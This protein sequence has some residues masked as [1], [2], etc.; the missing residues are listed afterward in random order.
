[1]YRF[2][3]EPYKNIAS[4]HT[5]PQCK[6]RKVFTRYI[7]TQEQVTLPEYVGRCDREDKCGYHL[8]PKEYFERNP[9]AHKALQEYAPTRTISRMP[10]P[11]KPPNFVSSDLVARTLI[12]HQGHNLFKFLCSQIGSAATDKLMGKYRVTTSTHWEG[13]TLFWQMDIKDKA[14]TGKIMLYNPETGRRV[15]EPH[16]H[17]H[18]AHKLLRQED[19]NL[20]QCFFGE[21]LLPTD[22]SKTVAIVESE[23]TAI[24]ASHYIPSFIWIATGGKNTCLKSDNIE[25]LKGHKVVLF[26]DLGA[27]E[28]WSSKMHLFT[29]HGIDIKLFDELENFATEEQKREGCDIADFLLDGNSP[30]SVLRQIMAKNPAFGELVTALDL[31]PTRVEQARVVIPQKR[32]KIR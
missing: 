24:I 23:K 13:A 28:Y 1:M 30:H 29:D 31:E 14:R 5:C 20:R 19:F 4:K 8:S 17:I 18:W 16:N 32:M 6:K 11:P 10:E 26:P 15:K 21:H 3:L 7:D 25:V 9:N 27:T 2:K 22:R 12:R